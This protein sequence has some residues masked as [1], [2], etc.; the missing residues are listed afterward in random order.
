MSSSLLTLPDAAERRAALALVERLPRSAARQL[1]P[2][3]RKLLPLVCAGLSNKE[4]ATELGKAETTIQQQICRCCR[5]LEVPSRARLFVR[6]L[7]L[8]Q[9][10]VDGANPV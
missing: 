5:K 3:E 6:L 1:S 9:R 2:A 10:Q 8:S 4:I 7:A